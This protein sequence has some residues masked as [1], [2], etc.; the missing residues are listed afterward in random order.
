MLSGANLESLAL[1]AIPYGA[2]YD[3]IEFDGQTTR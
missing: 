3:T 2:P 1:N